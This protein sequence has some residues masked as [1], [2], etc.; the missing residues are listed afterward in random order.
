MQNTEEEAMEALGRIWSLDS[1]FGE[2][3]GAAKERAK[4]QLIV[5]AWEEAALVD[6]DCLDDDED[7]HDDEDHADVHPEDFLVELFHTY[8][9]EETCT[10][11]EE[12]LFSC[13][14]SFFCEHLFFYSFYVLSKLP[15]Y[16]Y[17]THMRFSQVHYF[18]A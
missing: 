9:T 2:G 8:G 6:E 7:D 10:I 17:I 11:A 3:C 16:I 18:T 4:L 12:G 14:C 15:Y 13:F 5:Q 1:K